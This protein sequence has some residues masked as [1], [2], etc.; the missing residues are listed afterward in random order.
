MSIRDSTGSFV[1][2]QILIQIQAVVV[3]QPP[4][5]ERTQYTFSLSENAM[6]GDEISVLNITD[7]TGMH[8]SYDTINLFVCLFLKTLVSS[9]K[10]NNLSF[11]LSGDF[12]VVVGTAITDP[13]VLSIDDIFGFRTNTDSLI[14]LDASVLDREFID[15]YIFTV[16]A[17]DILGNSNTASVTITI[18]DFNDEAPII[19]NTE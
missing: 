15:E 9:K 17:T 2:R 11:L 1:R 3:D 6:S 7:E 8:F 12:T 13:G 5:F 4:R 10:F 18:S 19:T 14:V 16:Q